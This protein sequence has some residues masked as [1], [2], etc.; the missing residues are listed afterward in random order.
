[1]SEDC[2]TFHQYSPRQPT[3]LPS[4]YGLSL[5]S[6]QSLYTTSVRYGSK[7]PPIGGDINKRIFTYPK[8]RQAFDCPTVAGAQFP[9]RMCRVRSV[10][11]PDP[12]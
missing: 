11:L 6:A 3:E 10:A 4:L 5:R 2:V 9:H 1:M 12:N 7:V 8:Y